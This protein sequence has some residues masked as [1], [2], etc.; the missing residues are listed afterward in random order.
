MQALKSCYT[1]SFHHHILKM[2]ER[3]RA[4]MQKD[5]Q[6]LWRVDAQETAESRAGR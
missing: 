2:K 1:S 4:E 3:G 6:I 5:M